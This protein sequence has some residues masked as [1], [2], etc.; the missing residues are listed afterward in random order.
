MIRPSSF[1]QLWWSLRRGET[2]GSRKDANCGTVRAFAP[3]G[4]VIAPMP[5]IAAFASV[6]PIP[7]AAVNSWHMTPRMMLKLARPMSPDARSRMA[8]TRSKNQCLCQSRVCDRS[9]RP[10]VPRQRVRWPSSAETALELQIPPA[11]SRS[12]YPANQAACR[13]RQGRRHRTAC[14]DRVQVPA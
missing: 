9:S 8:P 14:R 13:N 5:E 7:W 2:I 12:R 11:L 6:E 3:S 10:D 4:K 1:L